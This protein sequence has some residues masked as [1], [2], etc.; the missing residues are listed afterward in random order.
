MSREHI[1]KKKKDK[2]RR[3]IT[4]KVVAQVV[5]MTSLQAVGVTLIAVT[6]GRI[7]RSLRRT[8]KDRGRVLRSTVTQTSIRKQ[9]W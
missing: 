5:A 3:I 6:N 7:G 1:T 9:L 4:T 8:G 2:P